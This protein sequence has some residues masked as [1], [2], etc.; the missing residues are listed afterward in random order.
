[1]TEFMEQRSP[2][3]TVADGKMYKNGFL[4]FKNRIQGE[5]NKIDFLHDLEANQKHEQLKAMSICCDAVIAFGKRYADYAR[6]LAA[7]ERNAEKKIRIR[8]NCC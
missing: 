4:D 7:K 1:M 2:G 5:I 8:I 6:E 3:H